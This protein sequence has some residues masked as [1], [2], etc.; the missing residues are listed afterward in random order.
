[1]RDFCRIAFE[2]ANLDYRNYVVEDPAFFRPTERFP[3]LADPSQT[4][5]DLGWL[6]QV[7]FEGLIEMMVTADLA[8]LGA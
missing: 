6:P 7:D 1:V 2:V 3:L 4:I 5:A 8:A